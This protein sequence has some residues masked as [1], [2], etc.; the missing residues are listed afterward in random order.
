RQ[1]REAQWRRSRLEAASDV[2]ASGASAQGGASAPV[3]VR[4]GGP[5]RRWAY[6]PVG[7]RAGGGLRASGRAWAGWGPPR[8]VGSPREKPNPVSDLRGPSGVS[9]QKAQIRLLIYGISA[10]RSHRPFVAL[11]GIR[12][13]NLKSDFGS[14]ISERTPLHSMRRGS[15]MPPGI[16]PHEGPNPPSMRLAWFFV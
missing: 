2:C 16:V 5:T 14:T 11:C 12:A 9:A 8:W 3:G 13:E 6:A 7:L 10:R 15:S 1:D 4:A